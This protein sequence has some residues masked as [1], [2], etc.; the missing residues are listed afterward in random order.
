VAY[1]GEFLV[2]LETLAYAREIDY[3]GDVELGEIFFGPD[4]A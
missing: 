3:D 2:L 1:D 4:A